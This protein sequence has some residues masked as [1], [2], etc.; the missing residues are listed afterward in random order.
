MAGQER[1]LPLG[2]RGHHKEFTRVAQTQHEELNH[3]PLATHLD[4]RSGA[5]WVPIDLTIPPWFVA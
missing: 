4:L 2:W 1:F 5:L 3:Q